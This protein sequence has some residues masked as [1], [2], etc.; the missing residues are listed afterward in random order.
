MPKQL[1]IEACIINLGDGGVPHE[2]GE[3]ADIPK[4]TAL[5]M[6]RMGRTL[7]VDRKD[8]SDKSGRYTASAEML[9]AAQDM[10]KAKSK[11]E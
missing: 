1:I 3:I 9:K 7:Y 11:G 2:P 6:A 4:D 5:S 8:D 10:A